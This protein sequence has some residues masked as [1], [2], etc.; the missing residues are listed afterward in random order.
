MFLLRVCCCSLSGV[1][2]GLDWN[3]GGCGVVWL[4]FGEFF[5]RLDEG[6][7]R[8]RDVKNIFKDFGWSK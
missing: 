5:D 7:K 2:R 1:C 6:R 4:D 8:E 3:S